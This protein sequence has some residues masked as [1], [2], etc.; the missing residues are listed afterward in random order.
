MTVGGSSSSR[1]NCLLAA[2]LSQCLNRGLLLR[3]DELTAHLSFDGDRPGW[4]RLALLDDVTVYR[5][6]LD[7][8]LVAA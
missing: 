6:D 3:V 7:E 2:A 4:A 8:A 1:C 5:P